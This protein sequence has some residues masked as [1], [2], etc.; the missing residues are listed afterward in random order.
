M[1]PRCS[2]TAL[3]LLLISLSKPVLLFI[4]LSKPVLLL[5]LLLQLLLNILYICVACLRQARKHSKRDIELLSEFSV[6][7]Y[8]MLG[9]QLTLFANGGLLQSLQYI[10]GN[11]LQELEDIILISTLVSYVPTLKMPLVLVVQP[12]KLTKQLRK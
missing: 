11:G 6:L 2:R 1:F 3:Q 9:S 10:D 8:L 5:Q 12:F 7:L 4:C